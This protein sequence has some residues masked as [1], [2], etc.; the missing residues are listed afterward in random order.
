M[1]TASNNASLR[2]VWIHGGGNDVTMP[3]ESIFDGSRLV[4]RSATVPADQSEPVIMVAIGYRMGG[5]GFMAMPELTAESSHKSSGNYGLLDQIFALKWVKRNI[6]SFGASQ[7]PRMVVF[8]ES[9][10]AYDISTLLASPLATGLFD[11]A[12]MESTYQV[13]NW[14]TLAQSEKTGTACAALHNCQNNNTLACM[15]ALSAED[16]YNCQAKIL[17]SVSNGLEHLTMPN[18]DECVMPWAP[19]PCFNAKL[20]PCTRFQSPSPSANS[21]HAYHAV[22]F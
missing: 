17:N 4:A 3:S 2:Q 5:L 11:G 7:T 14:V 6:Q 12:I 15:R 16:A 20:R 10:G 21:H 22:T 19:R 8:G 13:F 18:V 9:A 1:S